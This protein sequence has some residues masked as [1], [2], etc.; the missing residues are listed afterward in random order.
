MKYIRDIGNWP[1]ASGIDR[2][3]L[4]SRDRDGERAKRTC[5]KFLSKVQC[6]FKR[7]STARNKI[8]AHFDFN[9]HCAMFRLQNDYLY[10]V[11][12]HGITLRGQLYYKVDMGSSSVVNFMSQ[13]LPFERKLKIPKLGKI[14]R[15]KCFRVTIKNQFKKLLPT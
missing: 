1:K 4:I 3:L 6:N 9:V 8:C 13:K 5:S 11:M 15:R 10:S 12:G 14:L 7:S 2:Y